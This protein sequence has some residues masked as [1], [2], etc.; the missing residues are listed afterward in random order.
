[1]SSYWRHSGP[2]LHWAGS[3]R[4][5][6]PW[7]QLQVGGAVCSL[8]LPM[9]SVYAALSLGPESRAAL[10]EKLW[11]PSRASL[12]NS[13]KW[14][15]SGDLGLGPGQPSPTQPS[16]GVEVGAGTAPG[17]P[18]RPEVLVEGYVPSLLAFLSSFSSFRLCHF[19]FYLTMLP[20]IGPQMQLAAPPPPGCNPLVGWDPLHDSKHCLE[21]FKTKQNQ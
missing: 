14:V 12:P 10:A 2:Q 21:T 7:A 20:A 3:F 8:S 1:M 9:S 6:C 15:H 19:A 18:T 16:P 11:I 13:S 4:R 17:E 5:L